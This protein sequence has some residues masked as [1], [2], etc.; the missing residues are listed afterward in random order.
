MPPLLLGATAQSP[1]SKVSLK[2]HHI[3]SQGVDIR[4]LSI[5]ILQH[6]ERLL[7]AGESMREPGLVFTLL[8]YVVCKSILL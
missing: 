1:G 6:Q 5:S 8:A 2:Q 7:L 4:E 3:S